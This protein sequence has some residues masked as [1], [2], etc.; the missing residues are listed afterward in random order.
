MVPPGRRSDMAQ[1]HQDEAKPSIVAI[2]ALKQ[3]NRCP[4][5]ND[6]VDGDLPIVEEVTEVIQGHG[7]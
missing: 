4:G 1:L 7:T 3:H 6:T 5:Y 2:V